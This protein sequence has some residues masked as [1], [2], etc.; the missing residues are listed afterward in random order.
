MSTEVLD[1]GRQRSPIEEN[2]LRAGCIISS[3]QVP[4]RQ[5]IEAG[6]GFEPYH[7]A[8]IAKLESMRERIGVLIAVHRVVEP[9]DEKFIEEMIGAIDVLDYSHAVWPKA[10]NGDFMVE[11]VH[12]AVAASRAQPEV[13]EPAP[14]HLH[15][16]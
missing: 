2:Y 7:A 6:D 13:Q 3:M 15:A 14:R 9:I 10:I 8:E 5:A 1:G 11:A 12:Q 4:F 16:I